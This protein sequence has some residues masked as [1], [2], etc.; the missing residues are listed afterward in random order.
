VQGP[1]AVA[2]TIALRPAHKSMFSC[3]LRCTHGFRVGAD[4]VWSAA[5]SARLQCDSSTPV[6]R[7]IGSRVQAAKKPRPPCQGQHRPLQCSKP[8][9]KGQTRAAPAREKERPPNPSHALRA[10][11]TS[12]I[13]KRKRRKRRRQIV[14]GEGVRRRRGAAILSVSTPTV[15]QCARPAASAPRV[16]SGHARWQGS[17][18]R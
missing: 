1:A 13:S 11:S 14:K 12:P 5:W 10:A 15:W 6:S 7:P 16:V 3:M 17:D 18:W 4:S 9:T 8:A 2:T